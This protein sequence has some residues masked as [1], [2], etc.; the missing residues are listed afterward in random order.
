MQTAAFTDLCTWRDPSA[1]QPLVSAPECV[2][3]HLKAVNYANME[4]PA[5]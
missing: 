5:A 2:M 1:S 3:D 4:V